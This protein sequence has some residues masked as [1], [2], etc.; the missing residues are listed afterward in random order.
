MTDE[1]FTYGELKALLTVVE[2]KSD[3]EPPLTKQQTIRLIRH[4]LALENSLTAGRQRM[5]NLENQVRGQ[6]IARRQ[7]GV[8]G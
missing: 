5:T 7:S 2:A 8:S 6:A 3:E 1:T 4:A